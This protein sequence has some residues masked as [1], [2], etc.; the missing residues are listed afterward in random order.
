MAPGSPPREVRGQRGRCKSRER[1]RSWASRSGQAACPQMCRAA[2]RR[3]L[4]EREPR[5]WGRRPCPAA[6]RVQGARARGSDPRLPPLVP[7]PWSS[8]TFS[9]R[10]QRRRRSVPGLSLCCRESAGI[11]VQ[12]NHVGGCPRGKW[13]IYPIFFQMVEEIGS[14]GVRNFKNEKKHPKDPEDQTPASGKS[15]LAALRR[16]GV[17][18]P[19]GLQ[20]GAA[21]PELPR[22]RWFPCLRGFQH[23]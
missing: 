7:S 17:L 4:S 5:R 22:R 18:L 9:K 15:T 10:R 21:G 2:A 19:W 11:A 14:S 1:R 12:G 23:I 13:G 20:T 8:G 16:R 3:P 6:A